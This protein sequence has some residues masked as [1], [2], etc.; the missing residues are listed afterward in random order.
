MSKKPLPL[1]HR[2]AAQLVDLANGGREDREI[3][4]LVGGL[5]A[6]IS[7]RL[8]KAN[9]HKA[10]AAMGDAERVVLLA[11]FDQT[12]PAHLKQGKGKHVYAMQ[13]L[14]ISVAASGDPDPE[15]RDGEKLLDDYVA[16]AETIFRHADASRKRN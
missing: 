12:I 13:L 6:T 8:G 5:A 15:M 1:K 3:A 7:D 4:V 16:A 11:D 9:W 2:L 14:G 10:K